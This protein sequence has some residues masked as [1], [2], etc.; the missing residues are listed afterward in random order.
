MRASPFANA[1]RSNLPHSR[2]SDP[3]SVTVI[4]TVQIP[5][6]M[7]LGVLMIS[8]TNL[9]AAEAVD[10][11]GIEPLATIRETAEEFVAARVG[12]SAQI[13]AATLDSRL[14]LPACSTPLK[15]EATGNSA[16]AQWNV[17]VKCTGARMWTLYIPVRVSATQ[18][19]LVLSRNLLAGQTITAD[20][21]REETRDTAGL[22]FGYVSDPAAAIGKQIKRPAAAGSVLSPDAF[23]SPAMIRR[24]QLVPLVGRSNGFEVRTEGKALADGGLGESVAVENLNTRRIVQGTIRDDGSVEVRI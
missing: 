13:Q 4:R 5:V 14:Q 10:P 21:L 16:G 19:V 22:S 1:C 12:R 9:A 24:G 6:L 7:M 23:A 20:A 8:H 18:K 3:K 17:Q 15:A 11:S 2:I